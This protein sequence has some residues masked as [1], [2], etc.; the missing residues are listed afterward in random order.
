MKRIL[1][2]M[3][4]PALVAGCQES[5]S[6]VITNK[7]PFFYQQVYLPLNQS[8]RIIE[9]TKEFATQNKL[10]VL[11]SRQHLGEGEFAVTLINDRLNIT[12]N[13]V[14]KGDM[15]VVGAISRDIPNGQDKDLLDRYMR[16]MDFRKVPNKRGTG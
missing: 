10:K 7:T 13:N 11:V 3:L 1:A 12:T 2:F 16:T 8:E 4:M 6:G 9:E 14:A 15:A 5:D